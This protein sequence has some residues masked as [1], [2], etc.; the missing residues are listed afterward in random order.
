MSLAKEIVKEG[1]QKLWAKSDGGYLCW[2]KDN[3][4]SRGKKLDFDKHKY[5]IGV[6]ND[7]FEDICF[8]KPAQTG[9]TERMITE[10]LWLCDQGYYNSLY[11]FPT[12]SAIGDMVQERVDQPLNS[13]SYLMEVNRGSKESL[14]KRVDKVGLKKMSRGFIYF[15]G[16]N[17]YTQITSVAGDAIFI[18]ELD[19]MTQENVPYFE[20]RLAHSKL[21]WKRWCSTPTYP[22]FGID[23]KY[24]ESDQREYFVKC[25]HC[26]EQQTLDFF[27][28]VDKEKE[29]IICKFCKKELVVWELEGEWIAQR[30]EMSNILHG[31][32]I[33]PL[34]SPMVDIRKMIQQSNKSTDSDVQQFYNQTLGLAYEPKGERITS[35]IITNCIFPYKMPVQDE[36]E[37][38]YLG[39]DVGK[40]LHYVIRTKDRVLDCGSV[41]DFFGAE[42]SLEYLINRFRIKGIV[43][44]ALPETRKVQ[45]LIKKYKGMTK[46]CFYT[47]GVPKDG[48][49]YWKIDK[50]TITTDR[51]ISLDSMVAEY[52]DKL[53][54]VPENI[55][56]QVEFMAHMA[57]SIRVIREDKKGNKRAEWVETTADHLFHASNYAKMAKEIGFIDEPDIFF[58]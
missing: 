26:Q 56:S 25:N 54:K 53:I 9:I 55:V 32:Y 37:S 27:E 1:R 52:R 31:Y 39:V 13:S 3:W 4:T 11:F 44:D 33:S 28:N 15:R 10:S 19:R 21:K 34:L 2:V 46:M 43:I 30:P 48:N 17:S 35:S 57:S 42:K 6:Y 47:G 29:C 18:D 24:K 50:D 41:P 5:L 36:K 16:S 7:Q 14:G 51:T 45:E 23:K 38:A 40:V 8:K 20:K 22:D 12:T 49:K 58:I